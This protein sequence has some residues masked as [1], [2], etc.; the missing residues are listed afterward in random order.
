M[1]SSDIELLD[2]VR[3]AYIN[4]M[5][6]RAIVSSPV[7][8]SMSSIIQEINTEYISKF[9][10]VVH[11][12]YQ[13]KILRRNKYKMN[14]SIDKMINYIKNK[15]KELT[16]NGRIFLFGFCFVFGYCAFISYVLHGPIAIG[17]VALK[18][19]G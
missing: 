17:R 6:R 14:V 5:T 16:S 1:H 7:K 4:I 11:F 12:Y 9:G 18:F 8:F 19:A 2:T 15:I 10:D 13:S 3:D